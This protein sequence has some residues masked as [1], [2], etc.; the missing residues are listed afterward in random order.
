MEWDMQVFLYSSELGG[1]EK[2]I[3][4]AM[5]ELI[6]MD[7]LAIVRS[8]DKLSQELRGPWGEKPIAVILVSKKDELL[9][10]V[11]LRDQLHGVRLILILPNAEES[12][13]SL[14]HRLRPNYLTYFHRDLKELKA[15]LKRMLVRN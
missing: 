1:K 7:Q 5:E 4:K 8:V 14:A 3:R 11:S 9:D 13:I 2:Q 15:V 12:T 10:L 6:L